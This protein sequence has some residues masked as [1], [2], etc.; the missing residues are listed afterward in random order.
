MSRH[1]CLRDASRPCDACEAVG[2]PEKP[3]VH[4]DRHGVSRVDPGEMFRSKACRRELAKLI[5]ADPLHRRH[6]GGTP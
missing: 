3:R 2:A 4:Y 5:R 1:T 6:P